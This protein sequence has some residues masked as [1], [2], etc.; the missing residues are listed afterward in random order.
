MNPQP[1]PCS[2]VGSPLLSLSKAES[3]LLSINR[4]RQR[5]W[6]GRGYAPELPHTLCTQTSLLFCFVASILTVQVKPINQNL[7]IDSHR[8]QRTL[9]TFSYAP[10]TN[11]RSAF[12]A[13]MSSEIAL[14]RL[15]RVER[16]PASQQNRALCAASSW[17]FSTKSRLLCV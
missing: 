6:L 7:Q 10:R 11:P 8:K 2:A 1:V 3:D 5:P 12:W 13:F 15:R 4:L 14:A 17:G 16:L 9:I